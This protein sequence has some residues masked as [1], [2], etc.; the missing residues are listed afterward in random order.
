MVSHTQEKLVQRL[1]VLRK[2]H[3]VT[4]EEFSEHTGISYKY[5]QLVESGVKKE[6]RISTLERLANAYDIEV[7]QLLAPS[8]PKTKL[9]RKP[10][11]D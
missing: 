7:W 6:L 10:K 5:Y 9:L 8:V 2:I 4:Q 11:R 3:G 1:K